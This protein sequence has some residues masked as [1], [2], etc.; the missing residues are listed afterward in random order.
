VLEGCDS[1][2]NLGETVQLETRSMLSC[3][4]FDRKRRE[5]SIDLVSNEVYYMC[6]E[7]SSI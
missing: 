4:L 2:G 1:A 3:R 5:Y 7:G 6:C